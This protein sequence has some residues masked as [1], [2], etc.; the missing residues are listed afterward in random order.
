MPVSRMRMR[1]W[2]ENR[3]DSNAISGLTWVDKE[4]KMFSIPWKHAARH[5]WEMSKDASLFMEWAI[6]T[7]KY[8]PGVTKPDPKTWKA[9]FRCAMNSLPD[10]VEVKDKSVNKGCGA[11]RVYQM[12]PNSPHPAKKDKRCK[13]KDSKKRLKAAAVKMEDMDVEEMPSQDSSL[14]VVSSPQ[15]NTVDSTEK[16]ETFEVSNWFP[17]G[18]V[19]E[20]DSTNDLYPSFQVSPLHESDFGEAAIIELSK[21]L[22]REPSQWHPSS[23]NGRGFLRNETGT[24]TDC[25]QSPASQWSDYSGDELEFTAEYSSLVS[26]LETEPA[27]Y[28]DLW[29]SFANTNLQQIPC[30]L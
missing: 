27:V 24:S 9:N 23:I 16:I 28:T 12:L 20:V 15:E 14:R 6:H 13:T 11:V 3:I 2:L 25:Y 5:G 22:E 17:G 26:C 8:K 1:P 4:Q 19:P 7:G 18:E 21:Q 29:S 10:I 30:P